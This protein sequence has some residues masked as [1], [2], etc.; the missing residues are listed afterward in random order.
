MDR[1]MATWTGLAMVVVL[2]AGCT[3]SAGT[4][5]PSG[6]SASA[7]SPTSPG[8]S[9]PSPGPVAPQVY[10][11]RATTT[12]ALPPL[13]R[14][15]WLPTVAITGD[16]RVVTAGPMVEI[17]PGPLLPN[18]QARSLTAD[19]FAKIVDRA[20]TL[21]L[22]T[23]SGDFTPPNPMVGGSLGRVEIRVDGVLHDLTGDPAR[24]VRCGAARCIP[25]PGTPE[26]F[27]AFWQ[28]IA[29]L[30]WLEA[31]LGPQVAY[32]ADSYAI[33]VGVE[34]AE[35]PSLEPK[36]ITWPLSTPLAAFGIPVGNSP[37]QRCGTVRG[38]DAA[39]VRP[40]L[41]S[42]NQLTRWIDTGM[43]AT[44][45]RALQVRPMVSGE[46]VCGELFGVAP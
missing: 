17:Y 22:L 40:A 20:R 33:L 3:G 24:L 7:T 43:V 46:D 13:T 11:L 2:V 15:G 38:S 21:G 39:A 31:D 1:R 4:P 34:P 5:G 41:V 44:Q 16:L 9:T 29:D 26:A 45:G 27:A 23:G 19:G 8:S 42:A 6:S 25:D 12:Q 10:R 30:S 37:E 28:A 32:V 35:Q 18:L 14:F 36:V